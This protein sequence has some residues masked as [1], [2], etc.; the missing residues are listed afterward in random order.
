[1]TVP[2]GPNFATYIGDGVTTVFAYTFRIPTLDNVEVLLVELATGETTTLTPADYTITGVS[3]DNY[4]GGTVTYPLVG[5]P[6]ASTHRIYIRRIAPLTQPTDLRNQ[7]GYYPETVE[8]TLDWLEFQIQMLAEL[9]ARAVK[10]GIGIPGPSITIGEDGETLAFDADGNI[11]PGASQTAIEGA[12]QAALDAIEWAGWAHLWS[13]ADVD[14]VV[15]DGVHPAGFSAYHWAQQIAGAVNGCIPF[16]PFTGD[17]VDTTFTLPVEPVISGNVLVSIDGVWQLVA[18]AYSVSGT[19]LTF[20]EAPPNGTK[21]YGVILSLVNDLGTPSPGSVTPAALDPGQIAN[22]RTTLSVYSIAQVDAA[23]ALKANESDFPVSPTVDNKVWRSDGVAGKA[24]ESPV[25]IEDDG[26]I[27]APAGFRTHS[28]TLANN[29]ATLWVPPVGYT[30]YLIAIM[31]LGG[32]APGSPN[33]IFTAR[34]GAATIGGAELDAITNIAYSNLILTGTTGVVG[35][36]T[37][38]SHANG[39]Y[40]ENRTGGNRSCALTILAAF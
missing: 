14:Q 21:I 30:S 7:G 35:D 22:F 28:F 12:Q 38:S 29:V 9:T 31:T 20:T 10:T 19:T 16:G 8:F 13:S 17:G 37:I 32:F 24:Q 26:R 6:M 27:G 15:N 36:F 23:L 34:P 11:V 33:G 1:M 25:I 5:S 3:I 18:T 39:I 2:I 40:F 4:A